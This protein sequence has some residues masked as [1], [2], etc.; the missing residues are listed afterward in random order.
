M[1]IDNIDIADT[2]ASVGVLPVTDNM[3]VHVFPNPF[4]QNFNLQLS[5]DAAQNITAG[6]YSVD[7]KKL[8]TVLD[9]QKSDAGTH[10]LEINTNQLSNG[11]YIL[12][13]NERAFK[14][15]KMK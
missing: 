11:V 9:N 5:L 12:K 1:Y 14:L 3:Q 8:I 15:E 7:G 10:L 2:N 4:S 13:V 6:V